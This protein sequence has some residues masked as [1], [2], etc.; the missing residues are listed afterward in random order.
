[1]FQ[2]LDTCYTYCTQNIS[3]RDNQPEEIPGNITVNFICR[4]SQ[5]LVFEVIREESSSENVIQES[6][7]DGDNNDTN[8]INNSRVNINEKLI[9][10]IKLQESESSSSVRMV[11]LVSFCFS[12]HSKEN[13]R[14]Q[15]TLILM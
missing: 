1:M 2:N 8:N 3:S 6:D 5:R 14:I 7:F 13:S 11:Y 15:A 4:D 12:F 9:Y 10:L